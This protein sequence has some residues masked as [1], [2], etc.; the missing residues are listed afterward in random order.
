MPSIISVLHPSPSPFTLVFIHHLSPFTFTLHLQLHPPSF[1]LTLHSS[2]LIFTLHPSPF[3]LHLRLNP[4]PPHP[5]PFTFTLHLSPCH[6]VTPH[7]SSLPVIF[8]L[9]L[10]PSS[11]I[12]Y[13]LLFT[14]HLHLHPS[15]FALCPSPLSLSK[16]LDSL[17]ATCSASKQSRDPVWLSY[18]L[19]GWE[20]GEG[21]TGKQ[22]QKDS[23][24]QRCPE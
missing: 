10:H 22:T 3:T 5:L 11:L 9:R 2:P 14:P 23:P 15:P 16:P 12:L 17:Q 24:G 18:S 7:P 4:S 1:D 13:R 6:P 21:C 8:T 20:V 19:W